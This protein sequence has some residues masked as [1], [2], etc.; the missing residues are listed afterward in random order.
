MRQC[1]K[2]VFGVV[3]MRG[4]GSQRSKLC[5]E[6]QSVIARK[7]DD[8]IHAQCFRRPNDGSR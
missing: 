7:H 4:S 1:R 2:D 3:M 5:A 6:F 8:A